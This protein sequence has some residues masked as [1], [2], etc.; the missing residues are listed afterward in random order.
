MSLYSV[1]HRKPDWKSVS[2][3]AQNCFHVQPSAVHIPSDMFIWEILVYT[4]WNFDVKVC[5]IRDAHRDAHTDARPYA[6]KNLAN[7]PSL[8]DLTNCNENISK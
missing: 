4:K 5:Y 3:Y 8:E 6:K 7:R 1:A 2:D